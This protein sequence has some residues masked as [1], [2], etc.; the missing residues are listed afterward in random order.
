MIKFKEFNTQPYDVHVQAFL[1]KESENN[2]DDIFE[3][4]DLKAIDTRLV[5]LVYRQTNK[6]AY[7]LRT[8]SKSLNK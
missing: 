1:K 3:Y 5:I 4:V 2:P 7:Q 8:L 6:A